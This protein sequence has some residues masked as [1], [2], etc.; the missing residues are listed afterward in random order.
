VSKPGDPKAN[1]VLEK[2]SQLGPEQQAVVE[3]NRAFN[4]G[5]LEALEKIYGNRVLF[6]GKRLTRQEVIEKKRKAL[7]DDPHFRQTLSNLSIV[8]G[9]SGFSAKFQKTG[10]A[11]LDSTVRAKLVFSQTAQGPAL[12]LE[13]DATTEA[14]LRIPKHLDCTGAAFTAVQTHPVILADRRRVAKEYPAA[15]P[16]GLIYEETTTSLEGSEGYDLPDRFDPRWWVDV[17]HGTFTARDAYTS[18]FLK[19]T[20]EALARV[21]KACSPKGLTQ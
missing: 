13:T 6:Y 9:T 8:Q 18:A 10:G 21:E 17:R 20:P 14:A 2:K 5:D 19:F 11:K 3:W 16:F 12:V 4:Q 15:S 7:G 1:K